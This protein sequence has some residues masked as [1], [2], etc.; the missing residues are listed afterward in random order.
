MSVPAEQTLIDGNSE[1]QTPKTVLQKLMAFGGI[2]GALATASCCIVPLVLFTLGV[3][4][5]W[6]GN[7]TALAPYQPIFLTITFACLGVGFYKVYRKP[8]VACIEGSY[9]AKPVS[10]TIVKIALWSASIL[11]AAALAF[12]YVAPWL[13]GV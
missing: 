13:L 6:I 4:G 10:N 1:I 5:A 3:S 7:L 11:V 2:L 8:K 12:P 9:C